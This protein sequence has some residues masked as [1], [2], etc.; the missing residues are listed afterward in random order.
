MP[1]KIFPVF[2]VS[3]VLLSGCASTLRTSA[4]FKQ[5]ILETKYNNL[6]LFTND[7]DWKCN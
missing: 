7:Y 1:K 5:K 2:I 3:V 6:S 4:D